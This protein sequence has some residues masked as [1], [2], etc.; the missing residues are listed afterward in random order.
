M[1]QKIFA[2]LLRSADDTPQLLPLE[3][4]EILDYWEDGVYT[5][6]IP[7]SEI[8]RLKQEFTRLK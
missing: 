8:R 6:M 7:A 5:P 1:S 4:P 3:L 2:R